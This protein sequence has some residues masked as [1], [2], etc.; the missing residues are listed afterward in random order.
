MATTT[1]LSRQGREAMRE[2]NPKRRMAV[3]TA[4][5]WPWGEEELEGAVYRRQDLALKGLADEIDDRLGEVGEV[6]HRLVLDLAVFAI[7]V[8]QQ[9]GAVDLSLVVSR[10]RDDVNPLVSARHE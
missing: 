1:S 10:S 3:S 2:A 9:V 6:A 7:A 5:T 4:W 8:T